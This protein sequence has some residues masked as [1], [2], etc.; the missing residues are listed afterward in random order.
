M[1]KL[2]Q[3]WLILPALLLLSGTL[4]AQQIVTT[5]N[6]SGPSTCDGTA[7]IVDTANVYQNSTSWQGGGVVL[8]TGG[9]SISN[10]CPGTY[11]LTYTTFLGT[12]SYTFTIGS[13][14]CFGLNATVTVTNSTD[15]TTCDGSAVV[16]VSGGTPA[17][18]Y[19]WSNGAIGQFQTGLCAGIYECIVT[20][21]NGC[22]STVSGLVTDGSSN[23]GDTMIVFNNGTYLDSTIVDTLGNQWIIDCITDYLAVDSAFISGYGYINT[24]SV[25]VAWTVIDTNGLVV[26]Q[27]NVA[28]GIVNPASGVYTTMLTLY[29]PQKASE[30]NTMQ[31]GDQIYLNSAQMGI[32]ETEEI[33]FVVNNPFDENIGIQFDSPTDFEI[34]ITDLKGAVV[35]SES[36]K[37]VTQWNI[38]TTTFVNGSYFLRVNDGNSIVVKKL[39]K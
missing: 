36:A 31:I 6:T 12:Y 13:D 32:E 26:F 17:Y 15:S 14:P 37:N 24:D 35:Y 16:S 23:T 29:C 30:I 8:Q 33:D 18:V 19:Q 27:L 25:W 1:K 7:A 28:Y 4:S 9:Y 20:D 3:G 22:T 11:V 21:M 34:E 2:L 5:T 10:L 39:I 38:E